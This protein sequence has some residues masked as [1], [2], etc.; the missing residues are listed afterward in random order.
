[1]FVVF[2]CCP[3][4]ELY[5]STY[6]YY[7]ISP[8]YFSLYFLMQQI[9]YISQTQGLPGEHLLNVGTKTARFFCKES[10]SPYAA[11]RLK[12]KSFFFVVKS[13]VTLLYMAKMPHL[14]W[15][16][17]LELRS[18]AFFMSSVNRWAWDGDWDEVKGSEEVHLQLFGWH[19]ACMFSCSGLSVKEIAHLNLTSYSSSVTVSWATTFFV[20]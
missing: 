9:R 8:L 4:Y 3:H 11:W 18:R 1:M 14:N 17:V 2:D 5:I 15:T 6:Q 19:S 7:I 10:D 16:K 13:K 12:V 20:F